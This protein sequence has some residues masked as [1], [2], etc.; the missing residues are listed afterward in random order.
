MNQSMT[1]YSIERG[2]KM[3]KYVLKRIAQSIIV[4]IGVTIVTFL[5]LNVAPGDPV[6]VMLNRRA[7]QETMERVRHELGLDK[8]LHVQYLAF[9]KGT[10]KGDL[11]K[12]YFEKKPVTEMI[13]ESFK[14]TAKLATYA[15]LFAI[16]LGLTI[17]MLAA[18]FRGRIIDKVLMFISM[19]GMSAPSFWVG[20][21]LQ[22]Y[23][24]LKLR[25]FP[26]SGIMSSMAFVLP[27]LTLGTRYAAS[28]AR[29]TRTNILD[30]LSQD[31][32]RTA[33]SK[34]VSEFFVVVKHVLKNAA[35]PIVTLMGLQI[36]SIFGGSI[37]V[38]TVFS[39]PGMGK[40]AVDAIMARDIPVIQGT[41]VYS[42]ILF[43]FVNL[44]V[45]LLYGILDPR[46]RITKGA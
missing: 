46:I 42:A 20:I 40:L 30:I 25:W 44:I 14:V 1:S 31:Y 43:V 21:L 24:G 22:I 38:E 4:L 12:S 6:A 7:D 37:L 27:T 11:G 19:L 16:F 23:F 17:G 18:V 32:I 29:L 9:L 41:V 8:P 10:L 35:I 2:E 36:K 3:I 15:Y 5:L 13:W 45:D 28:T 39:I 34:G 33:R 26:I